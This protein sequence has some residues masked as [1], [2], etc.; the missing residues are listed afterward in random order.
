[1]WRKSCARVCR[2]TSASVP[3][4]STPV[5]PAPTITKVIQAR[6]RASS[7][8]RSAIS[9][10]IKTRW[11]ICKA[12]FR[13]LSPGHARPSRHGRNRHGSRPSPRSGC[14]NRPMPSASTTRFSGTSTA[15]ASASITATFAW[16]RKIRRIGAAMSAGLKRGRRH[17]VEQRLEQMVVGAVDD[18]D[19]APARSEALGRGQPAKAG[20][21]DHDVRGSLRSCSYVRS[22]FRGRIKDCATRPPRAK[23]RSAS[24]GPQLPGS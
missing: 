18:R 11:R 20:A 23:S 6:R 14:R 9:N 16:C 1:M 13:L 21:D 19:I 17:L 3:A 2:V 4:S 7:V 22:L 10:A 15:V 8:S 5:G 12:S 24:R